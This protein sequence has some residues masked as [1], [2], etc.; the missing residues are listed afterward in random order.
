MDFYKNNKMMK[1]I[2]YTCAIDSIILLFLGYKKKK[3][4]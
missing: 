3:N 1:N 2:I 4:K